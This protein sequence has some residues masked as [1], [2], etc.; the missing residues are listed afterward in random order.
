MRARASACGESICAAGIASR[1]AYPGAS[2]TAAT[3]AASAHGGARPESAPET[4]PC[5]ARIVRLYFL[6]SGASQAH[7]RRCC[8]TKVFPPCHSDS[9]HQ[10]FQ[11]VHAWRKVASNQAPFANEPPAGKVSVS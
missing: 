2:V 6:Q 1:G 4:A 9:R 5:E 10:D 3:A 7:M 11:N 8:F